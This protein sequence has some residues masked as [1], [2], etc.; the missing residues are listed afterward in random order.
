MSVYVVQ[1]GDTLA[2]IAA[3]YGTSVAALAQANR[4]SNPNRI[5][6]GQRIN[7]PDKTGVVRV[8][9]SSGRTVVTTPKAAAVIQ[10]AAATRG[11]VVD[12]VLQVGQANRVVGY[13]S[14]LTQQ[15]RDKL[16][17]S[18]FSVVALDD[19]NLRILTGGTIKV[20]VQITGDGYANARDAASVVAGAASALGYNVTSFTGALVSAGS[21]GNASGLKQEDFNKPPDPN[22]KGVLE[23]IADA[24]GITKTTVGVLG[25]AVGLGVIVALDH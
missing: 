17:T 22:K 9:D 7:V 14:T 6:V 20:R 10:Q 15:Y 1:R 23:G 24:L 4:I 2:R 3:R 5:A 13:S 18:G 12:V 19:T 25:A 16:N 11:A 21:G 8:V